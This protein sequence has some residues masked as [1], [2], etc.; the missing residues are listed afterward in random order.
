M[1]HPADAGR[2]DLTNGDDVSIVSATGRL[3]FTVRITDEIAPGVVFAP[4][5][6]SDAPLSVLAT[7][8]WTL[9]RVRIVK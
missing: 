9:P 4:L 2:L 5:N 6:L 1:I 3:G 7:D 8:M